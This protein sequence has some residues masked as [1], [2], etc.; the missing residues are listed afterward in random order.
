M[1]LRTEIEALK[2]RVT[3]LH[4]KQEA[5]EG[6]LLVLTCHWFVKLSR[7]QAL[8]IISALRTS[9]VFDVQGDRS[10][11]DEAIRLMAENSVQEFADKL[12]GFVRARCN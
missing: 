2:E 11:N 7:D 6:A 5:L 8:S 9:V 12:E 10:K 1:T 3:C 4:T